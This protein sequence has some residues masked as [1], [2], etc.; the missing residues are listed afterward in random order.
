MDPATLIVSALVAG[1]AAAGKDVASSAIKDAYRGLKKLLVARF[2]RKETDQAIPASAPTVDP[3]VVLEAHQAQ[4]DTWDAPLKEALA[5][6]GADHD[7]EI[8]D[9]ARALLEQVDPQGSAAGKYR[10]QS[11]RRTGSSG[12]RSRTD[13]GQHQLAR[14]QNASA[15][16]LVLVGE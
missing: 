8:L 4:P 2:H 13:D 7:Q 15:T 5:A 14:I 9:A 10:V 1:A 6:S 3:A 12:G 16:A 11:S